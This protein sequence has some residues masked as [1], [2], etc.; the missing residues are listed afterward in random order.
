MDSIT[1]A[2]LGAAIGLATLGHKDK[3][4]KV[5]L[6]GAGVA[7]IPDLDVVLLP[8][9]DP[10]ER[11]IM[12]RGYSHSIVFSILGALVLAYLFT[13]WKMTRA[14]SFS[15]LFVFSWLALITHMLLDTFTPYGTLLFLPFSIT[16]AG[17]DSI[18]I[19]D[20]FYTL[21]LLLGIGFTLFY[22]N[23][24]MVRKWANWCGILVSSLYLFSTLLIKA[25]INN[26]FATV[27]DRQG[28]EVSRILS[29]PVGIGSA[30]WY[31]LGR[32]PD[33]FYIG[34][35]AYFGSKDINLTFFASKDSLLSNIDP[36]HAKIMKW[37]AKDF[38]HVT[39]K[40]NSL[41]FYNMQVDMQG[42]H[43]DGDK[44]A[45]TRGYFILE[46]KVG[47]KLIGSGR[48]K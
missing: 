21:P 19:V 26:K 8:F 5:A 45:P 35:Y 42:L 34:D 43:S 28:I 2:S 40:G 1:Q 4:T 23:S 12:H 48:H 27:F 47:G 31:G 36:Y 10:I 13:K 38:Y 37:F 24:A 41:L 20:P 16:R 25:D 11:L 9:L 14:Y 32:T 6:L 39:E 33:G 29:E 30:H 44:T 46:N 17:F 22:K 18:N 3:P 15:R 7:T